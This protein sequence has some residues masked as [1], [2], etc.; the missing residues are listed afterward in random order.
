M[1]PDAALFKLMAQQVRDYGLFL[2]DPG[3]RIISWNTGAHLIKGYEA[4]E[5]VGRHFSVFY[6]PD[7]VARG[8]P[9]HELDVAA[10]EGRFEDEG[11]R[12][13]KDGSR[14][15]ANV[16][17]TAL[18]D[19]GGRLVAFS[20]ITRDLTERRRQEDA[21]RQSEERFRLLIEGVVDYAIYMLDPQG[22]I[23]SWNAGAERIKGYGRD[24]VLGTHFS[25]FYSDEDLKA[26]RP[27]AELAEARRYGRAV[28]EGWR[29]R[30]GGDRFWARVVVTSLHDPEGR[31]RGFA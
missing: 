10:R 15:W 29:V 26:G 1:T 24:E 30:K 7:A 20:K 8:W 12:V 11:F 2:L 19:E 31:L 3:G 18:R 4:D 23:S 21:L 6:T 22:M 17:I 9:E 14:F 28:D 13:R 5:I 16:I 25:R 27:W